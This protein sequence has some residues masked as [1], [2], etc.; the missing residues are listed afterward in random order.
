ME[1]KYGKQIDVNELK[2][3]SISLFLF[4]GNHEKRVFTAYNKV[5]GNNKIDKAF[6][7]LYEKSKKPKLS[8]VDSIVITSHSE[9]IELIDENLS[10]DNGET[11]IVIDYSC[12][13]K[14]WYYTIILYFKKKQLKH[15]KITCYFI[16][17]PSK[18]SLPLTPKPNTEIAPLPG[19]YIVPTDK[20]KALIVG[21]G[22]E[23]NKAEGIIDHLDPKECYLFYSK[24]ALDERFVKHLEIN[25]SYLLKS[26]NVVTYPLN[27]LLAIER[28]LTSIYYLLRDE[29]NIIIAPLGPKPFTFVSMLMT[30]KYNDID[31]WRV[32]SGADI[33]EY[34]RT[35]IS[36]DCFI[37]SKIIFENTEPK[38]F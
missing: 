10:S 21:L 24:P 14:S 25:N 38:E 32:G 22:Y 19:K 15:N 37:S 20:P 8:G 30:I 13:T 7:L 36:D 3:K 18:F 9:I 1:I 31:I 12:M 34:R 29:Y 2:D 26:R 16:Y 17:T 6:I 33:N 28:E 11:N 5:S 4:S 27:D 35:P 23:Q